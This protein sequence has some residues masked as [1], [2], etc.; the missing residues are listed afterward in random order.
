MLKMLKRS[1]VF[2]F[3]KA[4]LDKLLKNGSSEK[5]FHAKRKK[6]KQQSQTDQN[7]THHLKEGSL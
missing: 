1:G 3:G 6:K 5:C 4:F 2:C 7:E